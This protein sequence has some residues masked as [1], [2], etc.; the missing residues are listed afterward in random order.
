MK[1]WMI[2]ALAFLGVFAMIYAGIEAISNHQERA[3]MFFVFVG[4]MTVIGL[5]LDLANHLKT[6]TRRWM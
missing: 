2:F 3:G 1:K 5:V 4:G 6:K